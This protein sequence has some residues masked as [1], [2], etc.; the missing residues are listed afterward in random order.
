MNQTARLAGD[1][2]TSSGIGVSLNRG[3]ST[4]QEINTVLKRI[5]SF[6]A[7]LHIQIVAQ[8]I[9]GIENISDGLS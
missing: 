3:R 1:A 8:H 7:S 5:Y 9:P 2:S 4:S 6:L